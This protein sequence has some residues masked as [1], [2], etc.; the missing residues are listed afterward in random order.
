M[1]EGSDLHHST[2]APDLP[3][4]G[5]TRFQ[6]LAARVKDL[7]LPNFLD[8][9]PAAFNNICHV[10]ALS[11]FVANACTRTPELLY[12]LLV[13]GDLQRAY[14]AEK[15]ARE[16]TQAIAQITDD[17]E[18]MRTLR[19]RR[20]REL[21][22]IAWRDL[23]GWCDLETTL[24]ETSMLADVL[25]DA[26]LN[27]LEMRHRNKLGIPQGR[28][29][30]PQSLVVLAMGKLGSK[31]L[32]FSSD[33]DLVFAYPE[34]GQTVGS[35]RALSNDEF[36]ARLARRLVHVLGTAT[37]HGFVYRIDLRLRPFGK[38]GPLVMSFNALEEYYQ[39]HGR[40]WERFA[41]TR[42]RAVAG[43]TLQGAVLLDRL[44]PFVYRR[45]LDYGVVEEM[46]EMKNLLAEE[47][48]RKGLQANIKK[49]PG[50][51]REIEFLCQ[52]FQVIRAGRE[53]AL[54]ALPTL[55]ILAKLKERGYLPEAA[56]TELALAYRFLRNVE[57]RLQQ[58]DDRQ[59]HALPQDALGQTR[60]AVGMNC[61]DWG[62]FTTHLN[63]HRQG[64]QTH[65][66]QV[67]ASPEDKATVAV[68]R[69]QCF[70]NTEIELAEAIEALSAA[71][72]ANAAGT[73]EM[74][75]EFRCARR[76]R[77]LG[78][79][80]QQRLE[81][82]MPILLAV[83]GNRD[84]ALAT[85]HRLLQVVEAIASRSVYLALL[86][87]QPVV[88]EQ[89]VRLCEASP[90]ISGEIAQHPLLLDELLDPR[91]LYAPPTRLELDTDIA[92]RLGRITDGD[93]EREMD[94]VRQ[95]KQASVL[96]IA[97]ADIAQ[98]MPLMVVS[99]HLTAVA[100]IALQ[101]VLR[102]ACR[103]LSTRYGMP[104]FCVDGA[105]RDA[106]FAIIGYGKL[107]GIELG[108]ASDLDLVF[109]HEA[110]G[111]DQHTDGPQA[112]DNA[113]FF[114]RLAR[115]IIHF[116]S[117][118]TSAGV[119][120]EVDAR[121]RPSGASGLLVTSTGAFKEY[122][123]RSAWTWEHQAL[124][125][126]RVVA[127]PARLQHWFEETRRRVLCVQRDPAQLRREVQDMRQR[128]CDELANERSGGF[129]VKYGRG[130]IADIEFVVQYLALRW[131]SKLGDS[132]R[133]TD[134]IR[135]LEGFAK[136]QVL[137]PE[138]AELLANAYRS[139]RTRTHALALQEQP[140]IV[141]DSALQ[142]YRDGVTFIWNRLMSD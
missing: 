50:G 128:M 57:H 46:R 136:A 36:F 26:A 77:L 82:L 43:D 68:N 14:E 87:E 22:R 32:N 47:V 41:L 127:G 124:V 31:E 140:A 39:S 72:F 7:D 25:I 126:A 98:V 134:N 131:A 86:V 106:G 45:Y 9:S 1:N 137:S 40:G 115:R 85:T 4:L 90:W 11:D 48:Q 18:L 91:T 105:Y 111:T 142:D 138:D 53:P 113:V 132:L 117:A 76:Q 63:I 75:Y 20:N 101:A 55:E 2:P 27:P 89:L 62:A 51:I 108:Y 42:A 10:F 33:V 119:L 125:R 92:A 28:Q 103:D 109:L 64:V 6:A 19:Q 114:A 8:V 107:G 96:R 130:G 102:L 123:C 88:L 69:L 84:G 93:T 110:E 17:D 99:D 70:Q 74:I 133:F 81:R 23:S 129:D 29:G 59:T 38:S 135:L 67:F 95:F 12:S 15:F 24:H 52:S 79:A 80:G 60:L 44:R 5:H 83:I 13:S 120:Y 122:Q 139:Y 30:A 118:H 100:E 16:T 94:A 49:G 65:F 3:T 34:G 66:D 21:V 71:G 112:V 54:R 141:H 58:V 56:A 104:R 121:L 78:K 97:A 73:W 37:E 61:S 116:L 35:P